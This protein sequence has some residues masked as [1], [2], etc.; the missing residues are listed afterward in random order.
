MSMLADLVEVVIGVD[1]HTDTHTAAL[2]DTRTGG[3]LARAT[4]SADP[5]GY[6]ELVALADE[7]SGLR[8][9]ALEGSGGYGAGLARHLADAG[10][11]VVELDRPQ[12]PARRGAA[13]SDPIDAE[14]AARDA[15]A[16][17]RLAQPRTGAQR[18]ALQM[19]LTARRAAVE[20][21]AT[22][23][24]QLHAMVITAPEAVRARFRG[25]S[26]RLMLT[27]ATRLRPTTSAGIDVFTSLTVL[28]DLARRV[29]FLEAEATEHEKAIR[30]IVRSWRPD[31]LQLTGVG[32]I[33][34]AT[35]LTARSDP[36]RCRND[37]AFAMLA[38]AAPIPASSGKTV[39]YRLNRSGDRQLNRAL[40]TIVLTRLQRDEHT[41]TYAERRRT[42]G[43]TD[44]EIKRCLRRHVARDLYRRLE[45]P[46]SPL[47]AA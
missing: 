12:R 45:N 31:L 33:V 24:R 47:D 36:G 38:G 2:L 32:P 25:Q 1:T 41:R 4:V 18:A 5:D 22:A 7:H 46:P 43:K 35:I 28:R 10:E 13:K 42:Q 17:T 30:A 21:S 40:H 16:R 8:A 14:R 20:A 11:L 29:R 15:L 27:T 44:R 26:T 19:R 37:A 9:W 23:Q 34:A 6:A 39:R 3:V